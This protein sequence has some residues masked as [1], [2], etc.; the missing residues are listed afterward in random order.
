[1]R[2]LI[3]FN[4]SDFEASGTS[5][6]VLSIPPTNILS[7]YKYINCYKKLGDNSEALINGR[8]YSVLISD[9]SSSGDLKYGDRIYFLA[10]YKLASE[11]RNRVL[12]ASGDG[13]TVYTK[14]LGALSS[15]DSYISRQRR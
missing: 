11:T 6:L 14:D 3:T 9:T 15:S 4:S 12:G 2:V 7:S 13:N 1:M 8:K 10:T 5:H